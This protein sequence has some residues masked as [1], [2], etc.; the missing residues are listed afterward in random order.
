[1]DVAPRNFADRGLDI[2]LLQNCLHVLPIA[3][4]QIRK[5]FSGCVMEAAAEHAGTKAWDFDS[6]SN[7]SSSMLTCPCRHSP[8]A[9]ACL[10]DR[11]ADVHIPDAYERL[12]LDVI[13]G[14]QQHFVRRDELRAA[15]AVFTPLLEEIANG[16]VVPIPY[17]AGVWHAPVVVWK[18][19]TH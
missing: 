5:F 15:W 18:P 14:D 19:L 13:R 3:S 8:K 11:Y 17:P 6:Q 16:G 4:A 7:S 12:I 2:L 9:L 1:M 10:Q